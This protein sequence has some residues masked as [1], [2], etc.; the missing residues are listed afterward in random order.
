MASGV[1]PLDFTRLA[2]LTF[3]EADAQRFPGL[4]LS[5]QALR[6]PEGTTTVL[7]AANEVAVDAFLQERLRFDFIHAVNQATLEALVPQERPSS[8]AALLDL[9]AQARAVAGRMVQ[10]LSTGT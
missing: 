10:R 5:W 9:D 2:A 4:H 8:V 6:A 7:N 3:E 1:E